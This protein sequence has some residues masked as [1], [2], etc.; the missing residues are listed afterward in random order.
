[1][2]LKYRHWAPICCYQGLRPASSKCAVAQPFLAT[3]KLA[4]TLGMIPHF[5]L[6]ADC[7]ITLDMRSLP[8]TVAE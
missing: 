8:P 4:I 3:D 1:M 7:D 5:S 2:A 6:D